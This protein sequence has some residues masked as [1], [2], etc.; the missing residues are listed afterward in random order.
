MGFLA[1]SLSET[2]FLGKFSCLRWQDLGSLVVFSVSLDLKA[3]SED[4]LSVTSFDFSTE[5]HQKYEQ[6]LNK[7]F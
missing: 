2:S 1:L 5:F 6:Y 4:F 3:V 7:F